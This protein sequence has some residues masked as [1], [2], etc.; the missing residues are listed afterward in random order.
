MSFEVGDIHNQRVAV[1][2]ASEFQTRDARHLAFVYRGG[3]SPVPL[4]LLLPG[5]SFGFMGDSPVGRID[6][7]VLTPNFGFKIRIDV[8]PDL[9]DAVQIGFAV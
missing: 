6:D 4:I 3:S 5:E 8:S 2:A 7:D 9:P 1:S